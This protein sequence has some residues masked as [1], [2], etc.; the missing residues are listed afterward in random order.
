MV[1]TRL[2]RSSLGHH[3]TCLHKGQL[4]NGCQDFA[5]ASFPLAELIIVE[6]RY[7]AELVA[8][9][10]GIS[11]PPPSDTEGEHA[12]TDMQQDRQKDRENS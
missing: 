3:G 9:I 12:Q 6:F 2:L 4:Q 10:S 8:Q 1:H 11:I 5:S 7:N